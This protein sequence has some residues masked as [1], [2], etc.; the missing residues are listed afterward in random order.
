MRMYNNINYSEDYVIQ[1]II[2]VN[3]A[4]PD[5][6]SIASLKWDAR[7]STLKNGAILIIKNVKL[8]LITLTQLMMDITI[9]LPLP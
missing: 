4:F 2:L 1:L 3:K 7:V 8:L 9:H 6:S 5:I